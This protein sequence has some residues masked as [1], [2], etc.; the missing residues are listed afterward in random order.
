PASATT[1]QLYAGF[2]R[3]FGAMAIDIVITVA[4]TAVAPA[5][6]I[7]AVAL[8]PGFIAD[9]VGFGL[10]IAFTFTVV[11]IPPWAYYVLLTGTKGQTVGKMALGIK[12]V[13]ANGEK[14]GLGRA[15]LREVIGKIISGLVLWIGFF[16]AIWDPNKQGWHDKLASTYVI[17]TERARGAQL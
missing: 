1:S 3:R 8:P 5:I 12:V 2:W 10:T 15:A 13:V 6:V 17:R 9:G 7:A 14:P 16:W 4:I 11:L